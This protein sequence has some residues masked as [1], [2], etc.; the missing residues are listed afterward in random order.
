MPGRVGANALQIMEDLLSLFWGGQKY[1]VMG[2]VSGIHEVTMTSQVSFVVC[3][4]GP[5]LGCLDSTR[6]VRD[7]IAPYAVGIPNLWVYSK[8]DATVRVFP[9][10]HGDVDLRFRPSRLV[11]EREA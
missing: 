1:A 6:C 11:E 3:S 7:R 4:R 8:R 10:L 9:R 2:D 5:Q